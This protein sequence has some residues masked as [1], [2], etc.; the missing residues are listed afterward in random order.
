MEQ[1]VAGAGCTGCKVLLLE[2]AMGDAAEGEVTRNAR[3]GCSTAYDNDVGVNHCVV[4]STLPDR[5][6]YFK[7]QAVGRPK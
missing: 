5:F 3:P 6:S 4:V 2:E 7:K 1:S